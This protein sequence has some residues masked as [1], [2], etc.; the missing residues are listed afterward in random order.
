MTANT[1]RMGGLVVS[2]L[3]S[4]ALAVFLGLMAA[5]APVLAI[6]TT[7]LAV[8]ALTLVGGYAWARHLAEGRSVL[9]VYLLLLWVWIINMPAIV[10]FDIRNIVRP[11]LFNPQ[12]IGRIALFFTVGFLFLVNY[13][14]TPESDRVKLAHWP[15]VFGIPILML[16]WY[17]IDS[18]LVLD[19]Q[20][21][22]LALFRVSEWV[23]LL[24]LLA[25]VIARAPSDVTQLQNWLLRVPFAVLVFSLLITI[26]V[27]PI[28]PG[29]AYFVGA[30]G[31]GRLGNPFAHP[32]TLGVL[33]GMA[34]FYFLE[35]RPRFY[36]FGLVLSLATMLATYS[37]GAWVGFALA[38]GVYMVMRP[39]S[40]VSK[41]FLV[42][43]AAGLLTLAWATHDLYLSAAQKI[44][45][46]G[47][48]VTNLQTASERTEVWRA[49]KI[50]ISQSPWLG[51]G[52][53]AGPK[54]LNEVMAGGRTG[55][56][57]R[58]AH[59][60]NEFVQTQINAGVPATLLVVLFFFRAMYLLVALS[61]Y[62]DGTVARC[63][64]A[65]WLMLWTFGLLTPTLSG[66]LLVLGSLLMYIHV[67]LEFVYFRCVGYARRGAFP[68]RNMRVV[69]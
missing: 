65:W 55:S 37:R 53:V 7:L 60:H 2:A 6:L 58:A 27:L 21:L 23:L 68:Y 10:A 59:A 47:G 11:E 51:H 56:Y 50:L 31:I 5:V 41:A 46:R 30:S 45:S 39:R 8:S 15:V 9:A 35:K 36:W 29:R 24:L 64:T 26:V 13:L 33:A 42:M 57:F 43:G 18:L 62:A 17:A 4:G 49:A 20:E 54:K 25:A 67:M 69:A 38:S 22:L 34:F 40:L 44:L 63:V 16:S 14:R 61:R 48:D 3:V 66:Q 52:F 12:S 28:A 19:G 32:N 1:R